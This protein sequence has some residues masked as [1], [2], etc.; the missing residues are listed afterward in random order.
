MKKIFALVLI[1][2][3]AASICSIFAA[4]TPEALPDFVIPEGGYDGSDVTIRFYSSMGQDYGRL[5]DEALKEFKEMFPNITVDH[6]LGGDYD[7]NRDLLSSL[8]TTTEPPNVAFCYSDHVALYNQANA[9]VTL[10]DLINSQI[11]VSMANG[12]EGILGLTADE[13][14]DYIEAYYNEGKSFGDGKMYMLPFAKSTELLYFN[15][16]SF[17]AWGLAVPDHW[18]ATV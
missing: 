12:K 18:F 5:V 4:C 9:V 3:L 13:K 10:D 7:T 15:K 11:P 1:L 6:Q 8:L 17:D 14:A 2:V 16:T